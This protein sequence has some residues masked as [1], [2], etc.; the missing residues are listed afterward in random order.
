[1]TIAPPDRPL[2]DGLLSLR[3]PS[4][5]GDVEAV[6]AYREEDGYLDD[7]WL[8]LIPGA[9][10]ERSVADWADGWAGRKS[11]NGPTLVV[12]LEDEPCLVGVLGFLDRVPPAP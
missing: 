2:T 6:T 10:P 12:T 1:M 8:P 11:H 9:S 7:L 3:V 4:A 5:A